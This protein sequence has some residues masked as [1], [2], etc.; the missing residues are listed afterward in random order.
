MM[1]NKVDYEK[2]EELL[3]KGIKPFLVYLCNNSYITTEDYE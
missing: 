3:T 1:F 2:L